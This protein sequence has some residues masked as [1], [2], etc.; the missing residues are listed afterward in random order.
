MDDDGLKIRKF[1]GRIDKY[2]GWIDKRGESL[3]KHKGQ[4]DSK[5]G[6]IDRDAQSSVSYLMLVAGAVIVVG[7]VIVVLSG[8]GETG[9]AQT[10]KSSGTMGEAYSVLQQFIEEKKENELQAITLTPVKAEAYQDKDYA[11]TQEYD[12]LGN[13]LEQD[14]VFAP[15]CLSKKMCGNVKENYFYTSGSSKYFDAIAL[16]FDVSEFSEENYNAKLR[17]Y[18][19]QGANKK[20]IKHYALYYTYKDNSECEDD[21]KPEKCESAIELEENFENW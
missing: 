11:G 17:V 9:I 10:E 14:G 20:D 5:K 12:V 16:Q 6:D 3:D 18:L 4:I 21:A 13:V 8:L 1:K 19:K 7:I 2:K 15:L